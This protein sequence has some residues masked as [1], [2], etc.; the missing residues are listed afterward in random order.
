[1]SARKMASNLDANGKKILNLP[2]PTA[3]STEAARIIDVETARSFAVSRAN[4]SGTQL[5]STISDFATAVRLN[6]LDQLAAP[7]APVAF[8]GQKA[9]GVADP[10]V[11]QDAAT[12]KYVDDLFAGVATGQVFKGLVRALAKT[13]ITIATPGATIDGVTAIAGDIYWLGGQTVA[14]TNGPYVW[15][16]AAT[17]MTRATNWDNTAEAVRGSYWLVTE[18]TSADSW[19]LLT[20]DTATI[21]IGTTAPTYKVIDVAQAQ[22][23]AYEQDLGDGTAATFTLTHNFGT[24]NVSVTVYRNASPWDDIDVFIGRP[25]ANTV[26]VEPDEIWSSAQFHAVVRKL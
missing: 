26:T 4:H 14:N 16:G 5:A 17:P 7:T 11:A 21:T 24:R 19:L 12:K 22:T 6:R 18:G 13:N 8:G 1:M 25:D 23:P 3:G 9:T 10:T 20:N 15:N 2:V